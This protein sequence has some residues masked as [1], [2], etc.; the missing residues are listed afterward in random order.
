MVL[1][2]LTGDDPTLLGEAIIGLVDELVGDGDRDLMV[3][4][5]TEAEYRTAEGD[6]DLARLLDAARTPPFLT[7]RRVVVG[8]HLSRFPRKDDYSPIVDLVADHLPTTDL[9]LVWE[10][11][12]DPKPDR[13][14]TLPKP[15]KEAVEVAGGEVSNTSAPSRGKEASQW[16]RDQLAVSTLSFDPSRGRCRG[17]PG[18]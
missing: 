15:L 13:K 1:R 9:V 12:F 5:V 7:K 10:P 16:V 17:G 4:Q 2:L 18:R 11:G 3:E 6:Y 14:V 8:R